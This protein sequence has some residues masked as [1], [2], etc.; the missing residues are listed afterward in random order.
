MGVQVWQKACDAFRR[1]E[2][3]KGAGDVAC[4]SAVFLKRKTNMDTKIYDNRTRSPSS[5]NNAK[6][7]TRGQRIPL[8]VLIFH[9]AHQGGYPRKKGRYPGDTHQFQKRGG[10]IPLGFIGYEGS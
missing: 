6:R 5:A 7:G 3:A 10:E 4:R 9:R 1:Q 2:A 8:A